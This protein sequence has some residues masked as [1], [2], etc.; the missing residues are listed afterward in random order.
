M[1]SCVTES[2]IA[3]K[4]NEAAGANVDI[5]YPDSILSTF[6]R[7]THHMI[8]A[9]HAT[10]FVIWAVAEAI[11]LLVCYLSSNGRKKEYALL[12]ILGLSKKQLIVM[13]EKESLVISLVSF[14]FGGA[15]SGLTVFPFG[16]YLAMILGIAY[17]TPTFWEVI[18]ILAV[19]FLLS[20][21]SAMTASA[22]PVV[23]I[24]KMEAYSA[25]R[26]EE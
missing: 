23:K 8:T 15:L 1:Q 25:L 3:G 18:I 9:V 11:L 5:L 17:L 24:C 13:V 6:S 12:H 26:E 19:G 20:V 7:S 2:E 21:A 10:L 4:I 22:I 14:V 16:R